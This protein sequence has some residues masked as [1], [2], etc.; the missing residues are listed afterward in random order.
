[1]TDAGEHVLLPGI[2]IVPDNNKDNNA[3]HCR[4]TPARH[5][6]HCYGKGAHSHVILPS[7]YT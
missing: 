7:L 1:M 4:Y 2:I 3:D 5:D 6:K